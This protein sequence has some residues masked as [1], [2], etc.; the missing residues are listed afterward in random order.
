MLSAIPAEYQDLREVF[1]KSR[2]TSIPPHR[3]SDCGIDFLPSTTRGRLHTL[4]GPETKAMED[5]IA[6]SL[7]TGFIRPS[8]FPA[9]SGVL[10]HGEQDH[11][12]VH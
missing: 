6:D 7:V 11:A 12:P 3:P 9:G 10:L 5:S 8:S 1:I 2:D 4:S